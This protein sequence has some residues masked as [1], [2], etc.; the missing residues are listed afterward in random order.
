MHNTN[1][2]FEDNEQPSVLAS[3]RALL[4]KRRLHLFEALR[5]AELQANRLLELSAV[6]DIPVPIDV[7]TDLPRVH[8]DYE[9]DMPASGASDWDA[10]RKTWVITLNAL[11]P[12]TRQRLSILDEYK[13]I[14]DHGTSAGLV[15]DRHGRTY[16]GLSQ[17]EF[18]AEYFAG[19]VLMPKRIL[20]RAWGDGI[21]RIADLAELFDVSE[22]AMQVRLGQVGLLT[23]TDRN[24]RSRSPFSK[25]YVRAPHRPY[26]RAL[27]PNRPRSRLP[28]GAVA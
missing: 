25:R 23:A 16:Y 22:R 12:E 13:H 17:E 10:H 1:N 6:R 5:I 26:Y 18:L 8:V 27:S 19:C 15:P 21:Q 7:I 2:K 28:L 20:K 24:E 9:V 11:E 4:P 3:L 14:I